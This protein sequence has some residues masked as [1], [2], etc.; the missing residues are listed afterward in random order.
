MSE[1]NKIELFPKPSNPAPDIE[2]VKSLKS[3]QKLYELARPPCLSPN[4]FS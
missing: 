1:M 2:P 4:L 3:P